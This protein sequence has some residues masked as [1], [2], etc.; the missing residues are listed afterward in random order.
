MFTGKIK[1]PKKHTE[2][3]RERINESKM[4]KDDEARVNELVN[5]RADLVI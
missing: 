2:R 5:K 4:R 3:E 1:M